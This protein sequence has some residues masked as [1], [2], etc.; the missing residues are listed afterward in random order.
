MALPAAEGYPD[1][2]AGATV[3]AAVLN[4]TVCTAARELLADVSAA[5]AITVYWVFCVKPGTVTVTGPF[6]LVRVTAPDPT[7]V[8]LEIAAPD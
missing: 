4:I 5:V 7:T 8:R 6:A 1:A 2:N 3:S